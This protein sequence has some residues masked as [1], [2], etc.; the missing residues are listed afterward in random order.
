MKNEKN[1][2][3]ITDG[4]V[5]DDTSDLNITKPKSVMSV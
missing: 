2:C 1:V 3:T 5:V 4:R